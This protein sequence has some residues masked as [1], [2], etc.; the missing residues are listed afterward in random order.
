[1][2]ESLSGL[3]NRGVPVYQ[4]FYTIKNEGKKSGPSQL[5][6]FEEIL[7]YR[8]SGFEGFYCKWISQILMAMT[9]SYK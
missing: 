2:I 6:S 5:F 7:V 9:V 4:D 3:R 8:G 1:M